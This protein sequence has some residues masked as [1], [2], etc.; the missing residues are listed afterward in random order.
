[1]TRVEGFNNYDDKL[2]FRS[3]LC[4]ACIS[5]DVGCAG[6]DDNK[7]LIFIPIRIGFN[8]NCYLATEAVYNCSGH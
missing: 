6:A 4:C 1:M 2:S 5:A 3:F 7:L 8:F